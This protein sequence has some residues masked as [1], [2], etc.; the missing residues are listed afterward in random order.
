MKKDGSLK[1]L[2]GW[3]GLSNVPEVAKL[4]IPNF[5]A[6]AQPLLQMAFDAGGCG[7]MFGKVMFFWNTHLEVP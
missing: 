6:L 5:F 2:T 7:H 1:V 3:S 4:S